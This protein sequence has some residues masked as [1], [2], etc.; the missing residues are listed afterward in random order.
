M[1]TGVTDFY[2]KGKGDCGNGMV[3]V[4]NPSSADTEAAFKSKAMS[5]SG[6]KSS[7]AVKIGVGV[8]IP[9]A[10]ILVAIIGFFFWRRNKQRRGQERAPAPVMDAETYATYDH[11]SQEPKPVAE[12]TSELDNLKTEEETSEPETPMAPFSHELH[13]S[14]SFYEMGGSMPNPYELQGSTEYI[15]KR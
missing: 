6:S 4:S 3:F 13:N 7:T 2:S 8:A 1:L 9:V 11:L 10:A 15:T 14:S 12:G 5:T